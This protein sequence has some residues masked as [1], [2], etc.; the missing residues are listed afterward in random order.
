MKELCVTGPVHST[1]PK[2]EVVLATFKVRFNGT[3]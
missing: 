1:T 3:L 2:V